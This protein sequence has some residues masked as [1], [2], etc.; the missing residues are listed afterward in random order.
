MKLGQLLR[1]L[2][3]NQITASPETLFRLLFLIQSGFWSSF[4]SMA[5]N[6][7]YGAILKKSPLPANPI[8]IIGHWRT[9]S[10]FL[11][12]L[13][14]LD[15]NL[16][17]P[18]LYQVALPDSLL[19]SYKYYRPVFKMLVS[20]HRPMDNVKLGMDEPQ[21]DEYAIFRLTNFSPL[22]EIVFPKS[23][24]YF[25]SNY[26][27]F[28]PPADQLGDWSAAAAG[29]YRKLWLKTGK[30][31]VSKNPFNSRRIPLLAKLFP[32]SRFIHIGRNPLDVVPSTIHMW[33]ILQKQN[34]LNNNYRKPAVPEVVSTLEK[35]HL[36]IIRDSKSLNRNRYACLRFEDLENNPQDGIERLYT[37]LGLPFTGDYSDKITRFI[38]EIG[39]FQKNDFILGAEDREVIRS[40]SSAYREYFNYC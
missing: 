21:E 34:A 18:T 24:N 23:G 26:D 12:Q 40:G 33:D 15:P 13:L 30:T 39:S 14:S 38:K 5:E 2:G 11:H 16:A 1:L 28:L 3:R 22:E 7:R 37:S 6:I 19:V 27:D 35:M 8:F 29:F 20:E 9:G 36:A 25:L 10:T 4:F 17:A 31:I 32:D